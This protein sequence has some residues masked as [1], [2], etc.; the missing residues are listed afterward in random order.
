[1]V[2]MVFGQRNYLRFDSE[3]DYYEVIGYLANRNSNYF[4]SCEEY[5]N[6]WGAEY[7]INF[8]SIENMPQSLRNAISAGN[9]SYVARLNNNEFIYNLINRHNF[10]VTGQQNLNDVL[11]TIPTQYFE[12][13]NRGYAI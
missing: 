1:M 3:E 9:N 2:P 12:S 4:I 8:Y 13:F 5:E 7:R 10:S 11:E 6:K